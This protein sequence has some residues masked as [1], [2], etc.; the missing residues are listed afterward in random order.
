M[1]CLRRSIHRVLLGLF[2]VAVLA[3]ACSGDTSPLTG[4]WERTGGDF[5]QLQGMVVEVD[6]EATS[7]VITSVPANP[8]GFA[9]GDVKWATIIESDDGAYAF[10]DLVREEN[11][12][13][14]ST[15]EGIITLAADGDSL[16]IE[17]PETGTTQTWTRVP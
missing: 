7:A 1:H 8:F 10:D 5:S 4:S 12:G 11:T 3:A 6:A 14:Q 9:V 13:A 17:F 2:V 15:V 16:E